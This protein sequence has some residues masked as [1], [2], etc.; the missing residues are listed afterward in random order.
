MTTQVVHLA[1]GQAP[2]AQPVP[3]R[4]AQHFLLKW[5]AEGWT[6]LKI[7]IAL[8]LWVRLISCL[9]IRVFL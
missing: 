4:H 1:G 3:V 8:A 9:Y 7:F 5:A 6:R 2:V